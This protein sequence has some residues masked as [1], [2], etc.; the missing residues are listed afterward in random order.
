MTFL[1]KVNGMKGFEHLKYKK[2]VPAAVPAL[3]TEE[4]IFTQIRRHDIILNHPYQT[5]D[6]VVDFV[7]QAAKTRMSLQLSK[8][9]IVSAAIRRLLLL[10]QK[11]LRI[12]ANRFRCLWS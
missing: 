9:F 8:H 7:R 2:Y 12:M 1:M 6:P 5:F 11:R 3:N 10:W 4:D